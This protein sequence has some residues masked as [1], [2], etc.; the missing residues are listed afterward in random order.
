[1]VWKYNIFCTFLRKKKIYI[2]ER[3]WKIGYCL[4]VFDNIAMHLL[5]KF[6]TRLL[7]LLIIM[8]NK[9]TEKKVCNKN[10]NNLKKVKK[11]KDWNSIYRP[12]LQSWR[13]HPN[14]KCGL[15]NEKW[16]QECCLHLQL[17]MYLE[18][19]LH[20]SLGF[21]FYLEVRIQNR[22]QLN[23]YSFCGSHYLLTWIIVT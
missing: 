2:F 17:L 12:W 7:E 22:T 1:M 8:K 9:E 16:T 14:F 10:S 19:R 15:P 18:G 13:T 21:S 4:K 3:L 20:I 6:K 23:V 11:N 5:K